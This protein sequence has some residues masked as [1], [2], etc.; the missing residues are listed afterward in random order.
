MVWANTVVTTTFLSKV[1]VCIGM[2]LPA[3]LWVR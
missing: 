1:Y 2:V 3:L